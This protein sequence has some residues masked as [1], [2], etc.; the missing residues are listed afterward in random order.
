MFWNRHLN[1]CE[2]IIECHDS[3]INS[4][5]YFQRRFYT[6]GNDCLI[7]EWELSTFTCLRQFK[8]HSGPVTDMINL[9]NRL[10]SCGADRIIVWEMGNLNE[11]KATK[12]NKKNH[13]TTLNK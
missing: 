8:A 12:K 4:L 7:K 10:I 5:V 2:S 6:A 13:N 9:G 3:T 11:K 1:K